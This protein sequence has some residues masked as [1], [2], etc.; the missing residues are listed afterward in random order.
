MEFSFE[1]LAAWQKS[2][3]LVKHIYRVTSFFP[4]SERF[5]LVDQ[6]RRAAVSVSSN[7]A[8]GSGRLSVKEKIHFC[9]ISFGSLMEVMCQ[10]TLACDL[11]FISEEDLAESRQLIEE[12]S[13]IISGYRRSLFKV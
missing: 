7:L 2:R 10:L 6:L 12:L 5:G 11:G 9:E 3:I 4:A 1:R 13:R 8:E